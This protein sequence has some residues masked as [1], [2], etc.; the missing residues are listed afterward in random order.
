LGFGA[1]SIPAGYWAGLT[2]AV[3]ALDFSD[4][5]VLVRDDMADDVAYLLTWCLVE[6]RAWLEHQYRH[7]PP[8]RSPLTYPLVPESM[9]RPMVPL[10]RAAQRYYAESRLL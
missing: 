4:F 5:L 2:D 1:K 6:R 3:P 9:A 8:T 10:H 7:L